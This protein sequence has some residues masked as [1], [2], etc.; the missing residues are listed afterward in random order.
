MNVSNGEGVDELAGWT[1]LDVNWW[2]SI[3][4]QQRELFDNGLDGT[5][6]GDNVVA[7]ADSDEWD[8]AGPDGKG[9]FLSYLSTPSIPLNGSG[10]GTLEMLFEASWRPEGSQWGVVE[11]AYDG[12]AFNEVFRFSSDDTSPDYVPDVPAGQEFIADLANPADAAEAVVRFGYSGANNW[13]LAPR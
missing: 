5:G 1:F 9:P 2:G 12:G 6:L 13:W 11:V 10:A 8:D 7:V 3:D 4:P